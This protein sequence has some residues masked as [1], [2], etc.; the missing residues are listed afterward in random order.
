M[1][2]QATQSALS[3]LNVQKTLLIDGEGALPSALDKSLPSVTRIGGSDQYSTNA[4]TLGNL[5]PQ[6]RNLF[7][8]SNQDA[9]AGVLADEAAAQSDSWVL[10]D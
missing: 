5:Q 3:D 10:L 6:A 8:V 7:L 2:P 1:L 4:L 9:L